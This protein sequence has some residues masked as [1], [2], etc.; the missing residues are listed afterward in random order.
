[1]SLSILTPFALFINRKHLINRLLGFSP[2]RLIEKMVILTTLQYYYLKIQE[3]P[4]ALE[5]D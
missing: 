3:V 1:M 2:H 5:H 4:I